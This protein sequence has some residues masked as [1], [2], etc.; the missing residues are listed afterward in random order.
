MSGNEYKINAVE[1]YY[2]GDEDKFE[3][4]LRSIIR[5]YISDDRLSPDTGESFKKSS[6]K[7]WTCGTDCDMLSLQKNTSA[8]CGAPAKIGGVK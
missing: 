4:F 5:D 8:R 1:I 3:S 7:R 6:R 2:N